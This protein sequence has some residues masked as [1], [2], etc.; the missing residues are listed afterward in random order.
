MLASIEMLL[1]WPTIIT[2]Q[3][4][5][6]LCTLEKAASCVASDNAIG[7]S[8]FLALLQADPLQHVTLHHLRHSMESIVERSNDFR[9]ILRAD[10]DPFNGLQLGAG[11]ARTQVEKY[12]DST[13]V[14]PSINARLKLVPERLEL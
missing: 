1:T 7:C 10:R 5:S 8:F 13:K 6:M 9:V 2:T 3:L 14:F 11:Q 12:G 4:W